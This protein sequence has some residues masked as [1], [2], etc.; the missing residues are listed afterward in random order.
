MVEA[1]VA[2]TLI[3][4]LMLQK[5]QCELFAN[6]AAFDDLPNPMGTTAARPG[7]PR[8]GALSSSGPVGLR[9]DEE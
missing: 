7:G 5:A 9:V 1:M 4:A 8:E 2:L 3:D 6:E